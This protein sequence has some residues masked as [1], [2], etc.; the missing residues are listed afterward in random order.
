MIKEIV[1]KIKTKYVHVSFDFDC[2]TSTDFPSVNVLSQGTFVG[3]GGISYKEFNEV[4]NKLLTKLNVCSIDFVEY[5]PLLDKDKKDLKK[6]EETLK[7]V[8]KYIEG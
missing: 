3:K 2:I 6:V 7:L 1:N 8:D 4:L 5:N